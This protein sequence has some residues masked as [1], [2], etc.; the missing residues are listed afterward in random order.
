MTG[1]NVI[2]RPARP[3]PEAGPT[4]SVVLVHGSMDRA[5][6]F[7]RLGNHLE[8]FSI[9]S[10][11]RRG[12]A[13]S[14]EIGS[15]SNFSTQVDD[16]IDVIESAPATPAVVFGHSF[17][18]NIVLAAAER[19][20]DLV[21]AAAVFEAPMPWVTW[22]ESPAMARPELSDEDAAEAFM[23]R[24]IGDRNWNRLPADTR[25]QRRAEG[26]TLQTEIRGLAAEA[27]YDPARVEVPVLVAYGSETSA[28]HQ[29]GARQLAATL[30]RGTLRTVAGSN[31][32]G[33]LTHPAELAAL[34]RH[35]AASGP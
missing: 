24:M 6:S 5:A 26:R 35:A 15:S 30:P 22:W 34:I 3:G 11:D 8:D 7:R 16:L 20:P 4:P 31:H 28:K 21:P 12:Y 25:R 14:F 19:R 17:G 29:R 18:G 32:G 9:C 10:Y 13:D 33:H 27:P 23:C 1:L 2:R